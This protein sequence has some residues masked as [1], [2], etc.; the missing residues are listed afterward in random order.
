MP[1][2]DQTPSRPKIPFAYKVNW[3]AVKASDPA[4][5]LDTLV[6]SRS[7]CRFGTGSSLAEEFCAVMAKGGR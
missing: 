6:R 3:F 2:F 4:S 7:S 1:S 5:V